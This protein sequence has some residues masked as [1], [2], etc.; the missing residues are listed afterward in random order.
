[1]P[2]TGRM[3]IRFFR[4]IT[5]TATISDG[6]EHREILI[7]VIELLEFLNMACVNQVCG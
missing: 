6:N 4:I 2:A 7:T 3:S 5:L 1:M